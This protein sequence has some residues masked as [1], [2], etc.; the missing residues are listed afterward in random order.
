MSDTETIEQLVS[1]ISREKSN[2]E[3]IVPL[4]KPNISDLINQ[5]EDLFTQFFLCVWSPNPT[6]D[7]V[8][9]ILDDGGIKLYLKREKFISLISKVLNIDLPK[10]SYNF[11]R[12]KQSM[13]TYGGWYFYDRVNDEYRQLQEMPDFSRLRPIDLI[14][15]SRKPF[16]KEHLQNKFQE[17]KKM[18]A[19]TQKFRT[20]W[21]PK[22][23]AS[24]LSRIFSPVIRDDLRHSK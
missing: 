19:E 15:E 10:T 5:E 12:I 22:S 2:G 1:D 23:I 7:S 3:I 18:N 14:E 17:M 13:N 4:K 21:K 8:R 11:F 6:K 16:I 24:T 20:P 9:V